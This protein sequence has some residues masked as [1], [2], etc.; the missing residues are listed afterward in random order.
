[1]QGRGAASPAVGERVV[2]AG[3][4]TALLAD[5]N[6]AG[7]LYHGFVLQN[8]P[9]EADGDPRTADG[10]L[11]FS[12]RSAW[13]VAV[14]D[15]VGVAGVV[16]EYF[17]QTELAD[18]VT[19][20]ARLGRAALPAPQS[21]E[22]PLPADLE[23]LEGMR[24]RVAEATIAGPMHGACGLAVIPAHVAAADVAQV[25]RAPERLLAVQLERDVACPAALAEPAGSLLLGLT[26]PL[27][28]QFDQFR[29]L[30]PEADLPLVIPTP[31]QVPAPAPPP[32]PGGFAVATLN[33]ENFFD[34][35]RDTA[36]NGGATVSATCRRVVR[37]SWRSCLA[38]GGLSGAGW[39]SR[40]GE[41]S[42][43]GAAGRGG[44]A[45]L[46]LHIRGR[47]SRK[48]RCAGD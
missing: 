29:L 43:A 4:I 25:R 45:R 36:L 13:P 41:G 15:V 44:G 8:R 17:G 5:H 21:L 40:G 33:V 31:L 7:V 35:V 1:M 27:V 16:S 2:V 39:H 22:L 20:V 6:A 28:Y 23:P 9:Q 38:V 19:L 12:G 37:Q 10:L 18:E 11:V 47:S 3:V 46:R 42:A 24:V 48:P 32:P 14:G 30:L 26:G 34:E